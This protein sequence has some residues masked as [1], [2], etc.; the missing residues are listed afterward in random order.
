MLAKLVV[1]PCSDIAT[2]TD[3]T[4][5]MILEYAF[6]QESPYGVPH[7][8][9]A[10]SHRWRRVMGELKAHLLYAP[11]RS[12][13]W[14][15]GPSCLSGASVYPTLNDD[16]ATLPPSV[17]DQLDKFLT[18][19]DDPSVRIQFSS[20]QL[21]TDT[22]EG[23]VL[24]IPHLHRLCATKRSNQRR[25]LG[26]LAPS[27]DRHDWLTNDIINAV[28]ATYANDMTGRVARTCLAS[29]RLRVGFLPP[30]LYTIIASRAS[31][32]TEE[33]WLMLLSRSHKH[34]G[35]IE[36]VD[37]L[38]A[39]DALVAFVHTHNH[40]KAVVVRLVGE[41]SVIDVD[42][43]ERVGGRATLAAI[44][45]RDYICGL[46]RWRKMFVV[47]RLPPHLY[48]EP[49]EF[50]LT[51]PPSTHNPKQDDCSSCGIFALMV[52]RAA[53]MGGPLACTQADALMA[54][55]V[56]ACRFLHAFYHA[57]IDLT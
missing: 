19:L 45:M 39:L 14:L 50:K 7:Q 1:L 16:M 4:L 27:A 29:G 21:S 18:S 11:S 33:D 22:D 6:T 30:E 53:A 9:G 32:D 51:T 12:P 48:H 8:L 15:R 2:I 31:K 55:R 44:N 36:G 13:S 57:C 17:Q 43:L 28:A 49:S 56:F 20:G 35:G 52:L 10:V 26:P 42:S 54:R 47:K 37:R 5:A 23:Q 34:L 3:E 40:W 25:L 38:L 41:K 46:S 24:T